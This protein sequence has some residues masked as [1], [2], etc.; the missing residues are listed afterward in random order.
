[1]ERSIKQAMGLF[2]KPCVLTRKD[3]LTY[4]NNNFKLSLTG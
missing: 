1:M 4:N 2:Q 3:I